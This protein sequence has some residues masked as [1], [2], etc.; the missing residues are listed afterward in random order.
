MSGFFHIFPESEFGFSR[1]LS[2]VPPKGTV[3]WLVSNLANA[4]QK[5]W[6]RTRNSKGVSKDAFREEKS[7]RGLFVTSL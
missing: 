3:S 4:F 2:C 6:R 5:V 7:K 1:L